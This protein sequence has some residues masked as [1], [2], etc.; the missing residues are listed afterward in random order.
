MS[1]ND[2]EVRQVKFVVSIWHISKIWQVN[3][4]VESNTVART[5]GDLKET[6]MLQFPLSSRSRIQLPYEH[7]WIEIDN[8]LQFMS[9][10]RHAI[11]TYIVSTSYHRG[12]PNNSLPRSGA[13]C[14]SND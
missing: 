2:D 14:L 10:N 13:L 8:Q 12:R 6:R 3:W 4:S 1:L 7:N 9:I 11:L 5:N